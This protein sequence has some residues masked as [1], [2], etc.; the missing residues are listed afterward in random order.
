MSLPMDFTDVLN[1]FRCPVVWSAYE[2]EG[3]YVNGYWVE[4][5]IEE[6]KRE[7]SGILLNVDTKKLNLADEGNILSDGYCAMFNR[8]QT[9]F[10][11]PYNEKQQI[12]GKQTYWVIDGLEYRVITNPKTSSNANFRSYYAVRYRE[13]VNEQ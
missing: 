1:D 3:K 6:S 2:K 9:V 11:I 10:Y 12:N 5:I 7:V 13:N 4:Q 8:A